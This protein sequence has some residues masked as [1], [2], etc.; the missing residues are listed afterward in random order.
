M[1]DPPRHVS[2]ADL[3][4]TASDTHV[5]DVTMTHGSGA[6]TRHRVTVP[7]SLM[8]GLGLSAAQE[9][10]LVR[11]ALTYLLERSPAAVPETF[12]LD[13]VARAVPGFHE[14]ILDRL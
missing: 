9:P 2:P 4:I 12:E 11:A 1:P 13:E 7:E 8:S 10:L 14:E 6:S 5:Y 3:Q